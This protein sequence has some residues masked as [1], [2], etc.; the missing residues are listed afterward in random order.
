AAPEDDAVPAEEGGAGKRTL[1]LE[2]WVQLVFV[3]AALVLVWLYDHLIS[4]VWYLFAD[5][6]ESLVTLA[7]VAAGVLTAGA[8]Y[9]H[10][11]SYT[12]THDVTDE[13]SKVTWP[14]R[15]E[16]SS[17]TVVVVVASLIAA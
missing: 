6:D 17:S 14:T 3:V 8:L 11:P 16:T 9:R 12:L 10:R 2:R 4:A 7:A 1:G 5:P 15:K 13:L